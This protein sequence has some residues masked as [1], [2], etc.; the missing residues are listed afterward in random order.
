MLRGF[1]EGWFSFGESRAHKREVGRDPGDEEFDTRTWALAL[2]FERGERFAMEVLRMSCWRREFSNIIGSDGI[3]KQ[4]ILELDEHRNAGPSASIDDLVCRNL[5]GWRFTA[6]KMKI[7]GPAV[8]KYLSGKWPV[9][10]IGESWE[11]IMRAVLYDL[12]TT[13]LKELACDIGVDLKAVT[14]ALERK[15]MPDSLRHAL[16]EAFPPDLKERAE[17][18]AAAQAERNKPEPDGT[19]GKR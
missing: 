13:H 1:Q 11:P 15:D 17:R 18:I 16:V 12:A 9:T 10:S 8:E 2:Y 3:A 4:L 7:L 14:E 5:D 19:E 6:E